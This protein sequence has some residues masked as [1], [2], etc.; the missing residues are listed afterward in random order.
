MSHNGKLEQTPSW[1]SSYQS[2]TWDIAFADVDGD[3]YMDLGASNEIGSTTVY[4]NLGG[5]LETTPSWASGYYGMS[6]SIAW[7]D[8]DCAGIKNKVDTLS[9]NGVMKLFY[10]TRYPAHSIDS[11][12]V[13]GS[14]VGGK[15][16]CYDRNAGWISLRNAPQSGT[17]NILIYYTYSISLDLAVGVDNAPDVLF[18]NTNVGIEEVKS[19]PRW[20]QDKR[21]EVYPNPFSEKTVIRYSLN[22]TIIRLTIHD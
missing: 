16:Y 3:G 11:I 21:L 10:I 19:L 2:L 18:R 22:G 9:G 7:A 12:K 5:T 20:K 14:I 1:K 17:D 13:D 15:S 8:V 4:Q 6:M